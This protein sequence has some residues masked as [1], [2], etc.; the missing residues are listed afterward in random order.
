[1]FQPHPPPGLSLTL[2]AGDAKP[3]IA[4]MSA[5]MKTGQI[6]VVKK[7]PGDGIVLRTSALMDERV[8]GSWTPGLVSPIKW[9]QVTFIFNDHLG[10][11]ID[12][13]FTD[14]ILYVLLESQ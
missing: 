8:G 11:T 1:M 2:I 3:T 6:K 7:A 10:L 9:S 13:A 5:D 12:P 14:N 4:V